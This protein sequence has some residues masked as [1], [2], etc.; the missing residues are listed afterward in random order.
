MGES[1]GAPPGE[2]SCDAAA[3]GEL[4]AT[5]SKDPGV[6]PAVVSRKTNQRSARGQTCHQCGQV[7][8]PERPLVR[9]DVC[10][11]SRHSYD[12]GA[13][14]TKVVEMGGEEG[15]VVAVMLAQAR[16]AAGRNGGT[17][18]NADKNSRK[19][20][21]ASFCTVCAR[22]CQCSGGPV[23]CHVATVRARRKG[24]RMRAN[25][26]LTDGSVSRARTMSASPSA[27]ATQ[28]A[29]ES[30]VLDPFVPPTTFLEPSEN[31]FM[32]VTPFG[33]P[34]PPSSSSGGSGAHTE[35]GTTSESDLYADARVSGGFDLVSGA[36]SG[37]VAATVLKAGYDILAGADGAYIDTLLAWDP[38][39]GRDLLSETESWSPDLQGVQAR[40]DHRIVVLWFLLIFVLHFWMSWRAT[41]SASLLRLLGYIYQQERINRAVMV[42]GMGS[43]N[44]GD[45]VLALEGG[46]E[47]AGGDGRPSGSE[48]DKGA[49]IDIHTRRIIWRARFVCIT[50][51]ICQVMS[52]AAGAS[53]LLD[54]RVWHGFWALVPLFC[55]QARMA[56]GMLFVFDNFDPACNHEVLLHRPLTYEVIY[57]VISTVSVP[58]G[59]LMRPH[60]LDDRSRPLLM[61]SFLM[62]TAARLVSWKRMER[63]VDLKVMPGVSLRGILF[64]RYVGHTLIL[65]PLSGPLNSAISGSKPAAGA[66]APGGA[67]ALAS[68]NCDVRSARLLVLGP[69]FILMMLARTQPSKRTKVSS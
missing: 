9:C 34:R 45:A 42:E 13:R 12:C 40:L 4:M 29:I 7:G 36:A 50:F 37:F 58:L 64:A 52:L 67:L 69:L 15:K 28:S 32:D 63:F 21:T 41:K 56:L 66:D 65:S 10:G 46:G 5:T 26:E 18:T 35:S 24:K 16:V 39:G 11:T 25:P 33:V 6:P 27:S 1:A 30:A 20:K 49:L 51:N 22:M 53:G 23:A 2:G 62:A 47:S 60:L 68:A 8:K 17:A 14:C 3:G 61:S 48:S 54:E 55:E 59:L 43:G 19:M 38:T 57:L 31:I 44:G